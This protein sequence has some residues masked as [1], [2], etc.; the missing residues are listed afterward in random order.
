MVGLGDGI[1]VDLPG[2]DRRRHPGRPRHVPARLRPDQRPTTATSRLEVSP[3]LAH[4]TAGT[5]A[6]AKKLW[7]L[8]DRPNAMIK[9]PGH[10][11]RGCPR[12]RRR[13]S[14]GSTSTSPSC[15]ASRPTRPS[16]RPTSRPSSGAIEAGLPVDKIAS[17][18]SFF[19]S[20]I[21]TEVDKRIEAKIK[22]TTDPAEQGQAR[23]PA[24]QGRDRQRQERLRR[25]RG[26]LPRPRVRPAQGQGGAGPARPL[27]VGR[28]QEHE[29]PRHP[30]HRRPDRP[31]DRQHDAP[32]RR[33]TPSRTTATPRPP[34]SKG[35]DE[36]KKVMADLARRLGIDFHDVTDK[37]LAT[38]S[39][40]SPTR[41]TTS[42]RRS[43]RSRPQVLAD[44]PDRPDR[45]PAARTSAKA[46]EDDPR[47]PREDQGRRAAVVQG[48]LALEVR[49]GPRQDH[50]QRPGLADRRRGRQAQ[51]RR[52]GGVRRRGRRGRVHA[53]RRHGDG[54]VEPLRRGPPPDQHPRLRPPRADRPGQHRP[55]DDPPGR[56]PRSTR[57]RPCSSS[58]A[59]AA[60]TTEPSVFY[61]Y[62]F[63]KV[64]AIKGDKAG[65]NFVAITDPGTKMEADAKRDGFRRIFLNP[66]DIGGRYSALSYFGMVP[67]ALMGL[68]V[69]AILDHAKVAIE[70]VRPRRA[71][72]PEP[73]RRPRRRAS[74]T[75]AEHG[76]NKVTLVTP[77][78]LEALGLWIEQLIAESTGKEGKGIL[79]VAGEPL[80]RPRGLR[81]R[82]R[83]RPDPD[84]RCAAGVEDSPQLQALSEAGHPVLD[85]VMA[86]PSDLGAE[87]FR[88]EVAVAA[89]RPAARDRPV[90]PAERPG[91]QGQHQGPPRR[92]RQGRHAAR[93]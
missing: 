38:A 59:R 20:R 40:S 42:S 54:R 26:A 80:G 74:A 9:I 30:L 66:S 45:R 60:T 24:R 85:L 82:P 32:R 83:L 50:R 73:R 11:P 1:D 16:P 25:L 13:S 29:V 89:R 67:A 69:A 6:E 44:E 47:R 90:R 5:I 12:S 31:R 71:G 62:F 72:R 92:L 75:L 56:S 64:K 68:D 2:A 41:S 14:R 63:D 23:E 28:H 81:Q 58:P 4:D 15:S 93:A 35:C 37:L 21:D 33:S 57:P 7:G 53:R 18:A 46:V 79:P 36:A 52:P 19:V 10:R 61:A 34:C 27:G 48:R 22:E 17:V 84:R 8:L 65:E 78:P 49:R 91:E 51:R 39:S 77:P 76:R 88:W 55:R 3:L 43:R 87:F 70:G 86:D